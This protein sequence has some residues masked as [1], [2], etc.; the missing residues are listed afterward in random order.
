MSKRDSYS[1]K[2]ILQVVVPNEFVQRIA[3]AREIVAVCGG[4]ILAFLK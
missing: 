2:L 4:L 3:R 1:Q